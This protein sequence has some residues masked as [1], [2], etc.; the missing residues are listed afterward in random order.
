MSLKYKEIIRI[1]KLIIS[2]ER[3]ILFLNYKTFIQKSNVFNILN[4]N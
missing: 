1:K 3:I 4:I 2:Q